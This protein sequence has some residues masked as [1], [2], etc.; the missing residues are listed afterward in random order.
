M[1]QNVFGLVFLNDLGYFVLNCKYQT[2]PING[3]GELNTNAYFRSRTGQK[4]VV[5]RI[6]E[7]YC[8]SEF[9]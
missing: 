8:Y 3:H 4:N 6:I 7:F 5:Q 1:D 2:I 9:A